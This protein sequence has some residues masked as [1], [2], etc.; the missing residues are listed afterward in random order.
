MKPIVF[1]RS[2]SGFTEKYANMIG[3]EL[4]CQVL[5]VEKISKTNLSDYDTIIFGGSLHAIGIIGFKELKE[6]LPKNPDTRIFIF[7]VGAS[8]DK[9]GLLEEIWKNNNLD[10]IGKDRVKL[11]YLRGGFNFK[12]LNFINKIVMGLLYLRLK[13]LKNRTDEED[14]M[15]KAYETPVDFVSKE[16]IAELIAYV[17]KIK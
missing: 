16:N 8:P 10:E 1:Y 17:R 14:G 9:K 2:I 4:G 3:E 13:S 15:L 6:N 12:K 11:F 7:A 5:K